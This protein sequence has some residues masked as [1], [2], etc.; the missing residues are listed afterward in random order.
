MLQIIWRLPSSSAFAAI[1]GHQSLSG[2]ALSNRCRAP[3]PFQPTTQ[4][5]SLLAGAKLA[6]TVGTIERSWALRHEGCRAR[7]IQDGIG[8][9]AGPAACASIPRVVRQQ[10]TSVPARASHH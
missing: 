4:H 3:A 8:V 6:R 7:L 2:W 1:I 5:T 10:A 9:A